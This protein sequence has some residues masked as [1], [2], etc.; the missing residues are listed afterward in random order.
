MSR[1][2]TWPLYSYLARKQLR[3]S[4]F[5]V[6]ARK[7]FPAR[8]TKHN[9][10]G[11][12][13]WEWEIP[14]DGSFSLIFFDTFCDGVLPCERMC[15]T[16]A[17]C[18]RVFVWPGSHAHEYKSVGDNWI[19]AQSHRSRTLPRTLWPESDKCVPYWGTRAKTWRYYIDTLGGVIN[20]N[21]TTA[22]G[23]NQVGRRVASLLMLSVCPPPPL[24]I[25]SI[26]R[27]CAEQPGR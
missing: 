23:R 26:T 2:S 20:Y 13:V 4:T 14:V 19:E 16:G 11:V 22:C 9:I 6:W 8:T 1:F 10:F 7:V 17:Y 5:L 21:G 24:E 3:S 18:V 12:C 25:S 15:T 27:R